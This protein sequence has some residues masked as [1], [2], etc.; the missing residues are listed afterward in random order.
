MQICNLEEEEKKFFYYAPSKKFPFFYIPEQLILHVENVNSFLKCKFQVT[1]GW[2]P[3]R[4]NSF[5]DGC[6]N[7]EKSA[8]NIDAG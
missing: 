2:R 1:Y 8:F 6:K 3:D 7:H 4:P 5:C